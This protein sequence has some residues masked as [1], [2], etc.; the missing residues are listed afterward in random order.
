M[1]LTTAIAFQIAML[2]AALIFTQLPWYPVARGRSRPVISRRRYG[3]QRLTWLPGA[4]L[5][6]WL[7]LNLGRIKVNE[8]L[9]WTFAGVGL[10]LFA[11]G[12]ALGFAGWLALG[13]NRA[14][15]A[16]ITDGQTLVTHGV[17]GLVRHPA[18]LAINLQY[19]GA[20]LALQNWALLIGALANFAFWKKVADSEER[21]LVKHFG[22]AYR[23]YRR[24]VP[25]MVPSGSR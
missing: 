16:T 2:T 15:A 23:D 20:A 17:Y 9:A 1:R 3:F 5:D 21:L 12:T 25:Q 6:L 10:A 24:R 18:Y 13:A 11:A 14:P 4:M 22:E 19:L 7:A 8:G